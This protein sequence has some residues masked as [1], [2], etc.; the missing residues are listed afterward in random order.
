MVLSTQHSPEQ[1]AESESLQQLLQEFNIDSVVEP[2]AVKQD[3]IEFESRRADAFALQDNCIGHISWVEHRFE[4][5]TSIPFR[6]RTRLIPY[7]RRNFLEAEL[8]RFNAIG[9]IS[10]EDPGDC[11]YAS[12]IVLVPNKHG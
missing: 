1:I 4:I 10:A 9:I 6:Q 5:G 2:D 12:P 3:D 11:P 7:A 8:Q